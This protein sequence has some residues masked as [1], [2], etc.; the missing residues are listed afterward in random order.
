[1]RLL[2]LS[3][4]RWLAFHVATGRMNLLW[5]AL[6]KYGG[7]DP[8]AAEGPHHPVV[9]AAGGAPDRHTF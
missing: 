5:A 9:P 8:G 3:S 7:Q 4:T 2:K 6:V 1:M